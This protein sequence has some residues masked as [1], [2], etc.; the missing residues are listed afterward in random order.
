MRWIG[1]ISYSLYMLHLPLLIFF[2]VHVGYHMQGMNC[3]VGI[4]LYFV[5]ALCVIFPVSF[6]SFLLVE[7]PWVALGNKLLKKG[8]NDAKPKVGSSKEQTVEEKVTERE[9]A[10]W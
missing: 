6:L 4:S 9:L 5:W 3:Y 7:K 8:Q 2:M 10:K 1:L